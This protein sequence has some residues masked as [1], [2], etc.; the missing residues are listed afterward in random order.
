MLRILVIL[1]CLSVVPA[2][3]EASCPNYVGGS[4]STNGGDNTV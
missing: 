4:F 3:A 2:L 1:A